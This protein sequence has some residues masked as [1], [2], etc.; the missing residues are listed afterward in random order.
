M[1]GAVFNNG[2]TAMQRKQTKP[3]AKDVAAARRQF[4]AAERA[5]E[6]LAFGDDESLNAA[7]AK[8]ESARAV[9]DAARAT[10]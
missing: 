3:S 6:R 4:K 8:W 7:M 5:M 1:L 9:L 2:A 10:T